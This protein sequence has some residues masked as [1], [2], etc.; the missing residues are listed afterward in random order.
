MVSDFPFDTLSEAAKRA[1]AFRR[2]PFAMALDST[3]N[4]SR[5]WGRLR[6]SAYFAQKSRSAPSLEVSG[7]EQTKISIADRRATCV[8]TTP[9]RCPLIRVEELA[10]FAGPLDHAGPQRSLTWHCSSAIGKS[11]IS[12]FRA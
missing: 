5:P 7:T 11:P 2:A 8:P 1:A 12:E 4:V 9:S 10:L 3:C 6:I